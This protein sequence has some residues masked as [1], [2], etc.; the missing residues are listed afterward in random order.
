MFRTANKVTRPEKAL[1]L[2]FMAGS[3]DNPCPHLG[4]IKQEQTMFYDLRRGITEEFQR[5]TKLKR[6]LSKTTKNHHNLGRLCI[7]EFFDLQMTSKFKFD[8]IRPT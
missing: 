3:R 2:G 6:T 7:F 5:L 4:K 8:L 1:I